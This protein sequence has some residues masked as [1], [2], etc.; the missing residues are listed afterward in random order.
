MAVT[1]SGTAKVTLP[2]DE[3]ILDHARVRRAQA[4]RLQGVDDA[5]ARQALVE[6]PARRDDDRRDR[7]ARRRPW[8]YVMIADGGFEVAFHGEYR[9]IVPNERIVYTEVYEGPMPERREPA[10]EHRDVH[11]GGRRARRSSCSPQCSSKERATRSSTPAWR[12]G[13]RSRWTC[14]RRSRSRWAEAAPG[15]E[16]ES[17]RRATRRTRA[18]GPG[19]SA[20]WSRSRA[21]G[22]RCCT[23]GGGPPGCG[24]PARPRC[25]GRSRSRLGCTRL[26]SP[27]CLGKCGGHGASPRPS[28]SSRRASSSSWSSEPA[29]RRCRPR[30]RPASRQA[31]GHGVE[32]QVARLDVGDLVPLA[33]RRTRGRPASG[34]RSSRRRPCGRARS[35][36]SRRTRRGA[37]PSTTWSW[38]GRARGARPRGPARARRG[39]PRGSPTRG[40]MRTLTWMPLEPDVL[41]YPR[42]P[43]SSSTSRTTIAVRRTSSQPMPGRRGPGRRAARRGGR[44]RRG[45]RATG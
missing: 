25:V 3:Q 26:G 15:P 40:S 9:E 34:A 14:S 11:R 44:G 2:T 31:V 1:S 19:R 33:A 38:P 41:G 45:A 18:R 30:G 39:A 5:R 6:R 29:A 12:S 35:G 32:P 24:S 16:R 42:R 36:C 27:R 28:S 43:W 17:R 7:P 20:A 10:R 4:P 23:P 37:P 22:R 13:C 8:R 21:A